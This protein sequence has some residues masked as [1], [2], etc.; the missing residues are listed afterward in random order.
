MRSSEALKESSQ[1]RNKKKHKIPKKVIIT[2]LIILAYK[3]RCTRDGRDCQREQNPKRCGGVYIPV[4]LLSM[5]SQTDSPVFH[6]IQTPAT[7]WLCSSCI[8]PTLPDHRAPGKQQHRGVNISVRLKHHLLKDFPCL[9]WPWPQPWDSVISVISVFSSPGAANVLH[10]NKAGESVCFSA[11]IR[12]VYS[13]L[14]PGPHTLHSTLRPLWE[15][16][17]SE[18]GLIK[19]T[20]CTTHLTPTY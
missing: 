15:I 13:I 14:H 6:C 20:E 3:Q 10:P 11:L 17:L 19:H 7:C 2:D 9:L 16:A 8:T 1:K 12:D 5:P 4:F 18:Y